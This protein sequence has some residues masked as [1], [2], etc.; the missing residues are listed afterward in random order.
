[1]GLLFVA[2]GKWNSV[3]E[4]KPWNAL[5]QIRVSRCRWKTER[6]ARWEL[7]AR[8]KHF[9]RRGR[10]SLFSI[11]I[12]LNQHSACSSQRMY[13]VR[14][15]WVN[16]DLQ[17]Q[18]GFVQSV[19]IH[20]WWQAYASPAPFTMWWQTHSQRTSFFV[21]VCHCV[22]QFSIHMNSLYW[23]E[24]TIFLLYTITFQASS[25]RLAADCKDRWVTGDGGKKW[26]F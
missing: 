11:A 13:S 6:E 5:T 15:R 2:G 4:S 14:P 12:M 24:N 19:I 8:R 25:N 21:Q 20:L 7:A 17:Q 18:P 1:M 10:R 3:S 9:L 16:M 23:S 26:L 22:G